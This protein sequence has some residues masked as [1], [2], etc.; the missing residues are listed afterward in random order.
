MTVQ[1]TA[2]ITLP[3]V[4]PPQRWILFVALLLLEGA[5]WVEPAGSW[6]AE[7][8]EA[9]YAEIPREMLAS[10]D[11]VTPKLNGVP[12]LEKPPLLYWANAASLR[13]FGLTP[14]AARLPTRLFGLGTLLTLLV[15]T[16][17]IWGTPAGFAAAIFYLAAPLGFAFSRVNL[18]DA[19]LTFFF[20]L[21]LF[22][23]RAALLRREAGRPWAILSALA[24][25]AAAGG[26][27]SKGL[28]A[29]VLPG[30]I[31]FLWCLATRRMR[32]LPSLL[33]GPALP[34]FLV[35]AAPWFLL[36]ENRN[37]GFL[38]FFFIHEHFQRFSTS[39][40]RRPGPI[41][42]FV[43]IF[44]AGFLPG[45]PF[46]FASLKNAWRRDEPDPLFFLLW[47][48]I[49]LG[50]FSVSRSKLP[51]YLM[52]A[53]PAAAALAA[54][55]VFD[56]Q[57]AGPGAWRASAL[58][59][60]L[61]PAFVTLNPTARAWVREYGLAPI[62]V[63]G[64]ALLLLGTWAAPQLVKRGTSLA[65]GAFAA[66]WTGFAVM[67]GLV[68]PRIPPAT[69]PHAICAAAAATAR[70]DRATVVGYQAYLQGLPLALQSPIPLAD[71]VG[72]LEPQFERRPEIREALF[73]TREKFW[74]QWRS[75]N[76]YAALIRR[77]DL[78]EFETSGVPARVLASSPKHLLL[79]NYR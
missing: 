37:P 57:P 22:L 52:P 21:T 26:F 20:T 56:R 44:L 71:Y 77:R 4:S 46:F 7:P 6:L 23:A 43:L 35:A 31:L 24:G 65:L 27:L 68:W 34:V 61:L 49:V 18:T 42:Y 40:A 53:F 17:A 10:G 38:Q 70:S 63:S 29:V 33:F 41:Y 9:R 47:F 54:R 76:R 50:F 32:F 48:A 69:D 25:L 36:A 1:V 64:F 67:A 60:I 16:A 62:A 30:A 58:L 14:W 13:L 15:G 39:V 8:D 74:S 55:A 11:F 51:P 28:V 79:R 19:P 75:G 78:P 12:Y 73:W 2:A 59:A 72:E 66:G 5:V 45:V 3:R